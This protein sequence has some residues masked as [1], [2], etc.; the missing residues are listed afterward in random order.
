MALFAGG[1]EVASDTAEGAR[2]IRRAEATGDFLLKLDHPQVA[3]RAVVIEGNSEIGHKPQHFRLVFDKTI[4][5]LS[6][7]QSGAFLFGRTTDG[8]FGFSDQR[9]IAATEIFVQFAVQ[10]R[11]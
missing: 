1:R 11:L 4:E 3:L 5:Q 6:G 9:I 2:T 8:F 10:F 7:S